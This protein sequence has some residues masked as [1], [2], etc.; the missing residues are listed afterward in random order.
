MKYLRSLNE[1]VT[2]TTNIDDICAKYKIENYT[3]NEDDSID[4][5][6]NVD[7]SLK[8]L[9]K[10]PLKFRNVYGHFYCHQN[11]LTTLE[12]APEY[13]TGHFFCHQNKLTTLKGGPKK[14]GRTYYCA[15]NKLITLEG[16]AETVGDGFDCEKNE[17]IS[18]K[19]SPKSIGWTFNC[20]YN[21]LTSLEGVTENV[22]GIRC[23][24]NSLT[25]LKGC[26]K[27]IS[28]LSCD[29]NNIKNI[30]YLPNNCDIHFTGNPIHK[31]IK[32]F[33]DKFTNKAE[34]MKLYNNFRNK[35]IIQ[36][37]ILYIDLLV[38]FL[39]EVGKPKSKEK[40]E[41]LLNKYYEIR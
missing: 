22:V 25:S 39:T 16:A 14:V 2:N 12:G 18:L 37:D 33:T 19:G 32:L 4:V 36:N 3:I 30:D 17:L 1:K 24:Y 35:K 31:I 10:L 20:S 34:R 5:N 6:G 21:N 9:T 41:E 11:K 38:Q 7:L 29:Y 26:A 15:L 23:S 27:K 13:I 8:R 40:L 28:F